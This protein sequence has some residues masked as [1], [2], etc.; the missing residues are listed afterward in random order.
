MKARSTTDRARGSTRPG[1][2]AWLVAAGVLAG[3]GLRWY[4]MASPL[5]GLD[6]DEG[7]SALVSSRVRDGEFLAF[8]PGLRA[9]GTAL[10]YPR[11]LVLAL[12]GNHAVPAKLCEVAV[13]AAACVTVWR[14]GRR[15]WSELHGQVAGLIMW[16]YP[17]ATVWDSTKVRLYYTTAILFVALALLVAARLHDAGQA[18]LWRDVSAFGLIG[19]LSWWNHPMTL[20]AFVP[21]ALW[22]LVTRPGIVR[23]AHLLA[24]GAVVGALP[25]LFYNAR[26]DWLS[27]K[28]P[29]PPIQS[30][31]PDRVEGFFRVLLPRLIGLRHFYAGP[32][33]LRPWSYIAFVALGAAAAYAVLRWRG[34]KSVL[35]AVA[36]L[37]PFL[38]AVPRNSAFVA[39]PRYGMPLVPVLALM[40]AALAVCVARGRACGVA[41][42]LIAAT[43]ATAFSLDRVIDTTA[44]STVLEPVDYS[45][46]W[47]FTA[48]RGI[49]TFYADYWFAYPMIFE[50][51]R[52]TVII[53]LSG[54]YFGVGG[55]NQAG[56]DTAFFYRDSGCLDG[57]LEVLNGMGDIVA[58]Q[59]RVGDR[60]VMVRTS[61]V[62]P[63]PVIAAAM[64]P[65]C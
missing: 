56:S 37:F 33:F 22:V 16:V 38:F 44:G 41:A 12:T 62:V 3:V 36:A 17:A 25:W 47:D 51:R 65:R 50:A 48:E 43:A 1:L 30:S 31:Y 21:I 5:G 57:W 40:A 14:V 46:V 45:P 55:Q 42:L 20:Y 6:G 59:E 26:H 24:A 7:T 13:F 10:A 18:L 4:V 19:G 29:V 27:L 53:P 34:S 64:S 8:I 54:D 35:A 63:V 60:F 61:R 11:A 32:W 49:D 58:T 15:L 23:R 9:G 52:E 28:Q 2:P 39:E